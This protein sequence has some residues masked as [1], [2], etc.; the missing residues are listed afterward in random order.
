MIFET[1]LIFPAPRYPA[2]NWQPHG[3]RFEDAIF[4]SADGTRLHGWFF[5]QPQARCHLLY[6]HGNADFVPNLGI[7]ADALRHRFRCSVFI[8]DYRG[9][10]KSQGRP[11]EAGILADGHAARQWLCERTGAALDG[12]VLMGRSL[13]GA[14]A[15]ELAS[16]GGAGA[17]TLE[18]TFTSIPDVAAKLFPF[19]PVRWLLNTQLNSLAKIGDYSGPLFIS[20]GDADELVSC[21]HGQLLYEAATGPKQLFT[22]VGGRHNDPQPEG[23]FC[24]LDAFLSK[25]TLANSGSVV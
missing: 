13:G 16:Q 15:V 9:Y 19:F 11:N 2:G 6:C 8:F 24:E 4:H 12:I 17:L 20:H 7:Y 10:G 25:F 1:A 18:N 5:D 21:E 22:V 14:V 3:L 23:Y